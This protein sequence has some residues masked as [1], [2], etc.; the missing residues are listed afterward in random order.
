MNHLQVL[1]R[2]RRRGFLNRLRGQGRPARFAV[3]GLIM[4]LGAGLLALGYFAAPG[5]LKPPEDLVTAVGMKTSED[6]LPAGAAALEAAFWLAALCSSVLNFRVM[7]LLFRRKDVRALEHFPLGLSALYIDRLLATLFEALGAAF[8]VALFFLPLIWRGGALAAL[9]S[10][11]LVTVGLLTSAALGFALQLGAGASVG[12]TAE[13]EPSTPRATRSNT[14]S[15]A[16]QVFL[17]APGI[18]L[19][20]SVI[21]ILMAKL[22][23]GEVLKAGAPTRAFGVGLGILGL[24][25]GGA[26]ISSFRSFLRAFPQMSARFHEVD[27]VGYTVSASH[28]V[29]D[30][31]KKRFGERLLPAAA[32][33][34]YRGYALQFGR[35]Y[36]LMRWGYGL[37]WLAAGIALFRASEAALPAWLIASL[38]AILAATLV[39]PWRRLSSERIRPAYQRLLPLSTRLDDRAAQTFTL[40]ELALFC[41]P[42]ALLVLLSRGLRF[43]NWSQGLALAALAILACAALNGALSLA[44]RFV[45]RSR[46][47]E[48]LIPLLMALLFV[49]A[50]NL[51]L[52]ALFIA[53]ALFAIGHLPLF[54]TPDADSA[55]GSIYQA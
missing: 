18:A 14:S 44:W 38:P 52:W 16:S 50:G 47:A 11:S 24:V 33:P 41:A 36:T 32:R 49:A 3:F 28:Q 37:S 42:Y 40:G 26:I 13:A 4:L 30:F 10:T 45:G 35:S 46:P 15:G 17:Y 55:P 51:S 8:C 21:V 29:S 9:V 20:V 7:E 53:S 23:F 5:L 31:A 2:A 48:L 1:M 43:Q 6:P 27:F 34:L 19:A 22:A 39:N 12:E 25:F 54:F